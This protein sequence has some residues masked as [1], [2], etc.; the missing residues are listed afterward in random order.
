MTMKYRWLTLV[1]AIFLAQGCASVAVDRAK[2]L[3]AAGIAYS[4]AT[5]AVV[6]VAMD[7]HVDNDSLAQIASVPRPPV[8]SEVQERR[9][10]KLEELDASLVTSLQLYNRL[11]HS[12]FAVRGY[13]AALQALANGSQAGATGQAVQGLAGQVSAL[14]AALEG[15]S[16]KPLISEAQVKALGGLAKVVAAQV[17]GAKLAAALERDAPVI[18]RALILQESVLKIAGDDIRTYMRDTNDQLFLKRVK[19]PYQK[20]EYG[21]DW[22]ND[23]RVYLKVRAFGAVSDQLDVAAM[24]SSKMQLIWQRILS[25]SY[26]TAEIAASLKEVQELLDAVASLKTATEAAE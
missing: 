16:A 10:A 5:V 9:A 20:G 13:F 11:K 14:N 6:E 25:G 12:L 3:S 7:A 17:H 26:S 19:A 23:R 4:D 2:D 15:A 18:G 24:A 22:A 1:F 21:S 8:S